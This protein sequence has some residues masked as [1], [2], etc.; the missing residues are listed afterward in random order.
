QGGVQGTIYYQNL[1]NLRIGVEVDDPAYGALPGCP[2]GRV[3][4]Y[5]DSL[6]ALY[7]SAALGDFSH[8]ANTNLGSLFTIA[9]IRTVRA[10]IPFPSVGQ[11][12]YKVGRTTGSSGGSVVASC[13][14]INVSGTNISML[15]QDVV[16]AAAG[17]GDSGS[18][19]FFIVNGVGDIYAV[20]LVWGINSTGTQF[21][22]S[23]LEN[24]E[25]ELGPLTLF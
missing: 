16:N 23:A 9:P 4:R 7:D 3:C 24:I 20:G 13:V 2:V 1:P 6:F 8:V 10:E 25:F 22:M 5:S 21:I 18:P 19:A 12:V 17:P 15:C 14:N 11:V